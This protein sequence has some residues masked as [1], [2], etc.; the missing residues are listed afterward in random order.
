MA[1]DPKIVALMAPQH[2]TTVTYVNQA[3]AQSTEELLAAESP[4]KDT[5]IL[6]YI[7][8]VQTETV[9][10]A[11]EGTPDAALPVLSIAAPF[12]GPRSSRRARVHSRHRGPVHLRQ[13]A[14]AVTLTGA[15]LKDYLEYSAKYFNQRP[16]RAGRP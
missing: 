2:D 10:A 15:Q 4:Y 5:P 13:H 8:K 11:L 6:D 16:R 14:E 7:H 3:V 9:K 12:R 1:E